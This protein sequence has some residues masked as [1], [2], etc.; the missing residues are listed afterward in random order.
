[1]NTLAKPEDMI[2]AS[3]PVIPRLLP[4]TE[5]RLQLNSNTSYGQ[6]GS[7]VL[8]AF[9]GSVVLGVLA[10]K[11][12]VWIGDILTPPLPIDVFSVWWR[13]GLTIT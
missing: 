12:G 7:A 13:M 3:V 9:F 8:L 10:Y 2:R 11:A 5:L 1:M 6:E 4:R